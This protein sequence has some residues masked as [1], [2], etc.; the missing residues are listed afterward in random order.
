MGVC[1]GEF[2]ARKTEVS[3]IHSLIKPDGYRQ[4][5]RPKNY[6]CKIITHNQ[7]GTGFLIILFKGNKKF[8]CLMTNE[9]VVNKEMIKQRETIIINYDYESQFIQIKLNPEERFIKDFTDIKVDA[10]VIEIL[11]K[12]NIDEECF[13]FPIPDCIRDYNDFVGKD[14]AIVQYPYGKLKYACGK[15]KRMTYVTNYEFVHDASTCKGSSGS[16]IFIEGT[17]IVIGIHKGGTEIKTE[18]KTIIENYGD[19]IWP[20]YNYLKNFPGNK[21]GFEQINR[22][23]TI[24]ENDKKNTQKNTDFDV[25]NQMTIIY[26]ISSLDYSIYLFGDRFV[27]NNKNNCLLLIDGQHKDL[28]HELS[29]N[30]EQQKRNLLEIKLLQ[31]KSFTDMS[32]MFRGCKTLIYLKVISKWDTKNVTDMSDM[33]SGCKSL[34]SLPDISK[35]D[36]KNVTNMSDMFSDCDSLNNL[37]DISEWDTK[38]VTDMSDIFYDFDNK[39]KFRKK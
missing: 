22:F 9:H 16:P 35:W 8:Y 39:I 5:I 18:N 12:D 26:E 13:I 19:F 1:F 21:E 34:K 15:I 11:P 20:V 23:N 29:L 30:R 37:P 27:I 31:I 7:L 36:T 28:C 10:T 33:F 2:S 38:N 32:N 6:I 25:L 3:A 24:N 17:K 4:V 14:I